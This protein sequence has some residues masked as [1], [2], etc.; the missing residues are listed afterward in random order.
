MYRKEFGFF[1]NY[2]FQL[3]IV[4]NYIRK[5]ILD[6][7]NLATGSLCI[8][9]TN[10]QDFENCVDRSLKLFLFCEILM[11]YR[12]LYSCSS[13]SVEEHPY[14]NRIEPEIGVKCQ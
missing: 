7:R 10:I 9:C 5:P 11:S 12:A 4:I 6:Y 2:L 1:M 3:F 13:A 8:L 14:K